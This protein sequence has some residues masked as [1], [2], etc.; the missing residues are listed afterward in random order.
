MNVMA[1]QSEEDAQNS[2][3]E[4]EFCDEDA[5]AKYWAITIKCLQKW[6]A[7]GEG[8]AYYKIGKSVRY[9][10]S[11]IEDFERRNRIAPTT[12]PSA[13]DECLRRRV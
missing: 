13:S 3:V 10:R 5:L 2:L 7:L 12:G 11:D 1:P 9:K 8:P 4:N 6:R